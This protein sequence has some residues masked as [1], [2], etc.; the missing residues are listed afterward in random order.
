MGTLLLRGFAASA[1]R[2]AAKNWHRLRAPSVGC[3]LWV[4]LFTQTSPLLETQPR[5]HC[6]P[7][8]VA[9]RLAFCLGTALLTALPNYSRARAIC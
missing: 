2:C 1:S 3:L 9:P 5:Q 7:G 8:L 4:D 6:V